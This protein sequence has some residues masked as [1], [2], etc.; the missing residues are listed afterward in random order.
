MGSLQIFRK[1]F[2]NPGKAFNNLLGKPRHLRTGFLFLL[3]PI[4]GYTLMYQFLTLA[5][6]APSVFTPW[7][8]I[9]KEKYYYWNRFLLAPSILLSWI[10]AAAS[11]HL[12]SLAGGGK[13]SFEQTISLV[14]LSVSVSMCYGLMHDLPV[15]ILSALK[16]IDAKQH[17]VDMNSPTPWRIMLWSFYTAYFL[18]FIILFTKTTSVVH[19]LNKGLSLAIGFAGFILFQLVFLV[20]NR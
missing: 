13:G 7:L 2:F 20:F 19:R 5:H 18:S 11:M 15:S 1:T 10:A 14:A 3:I 12:L 4:V 17:E 9:P 6:G 8:N 16:V